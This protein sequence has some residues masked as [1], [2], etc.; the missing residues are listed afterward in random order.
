M[1][2]ASEIDAE[3]AADDGMERGVERTDGWPAAEARQDFDQR[4]RQERQR[5]FAQAREVF[6]DQLAEVI[7]THRPNKLIGLERAAATLSDEE[8]HPLADAVSI[9]IQLIPV[10]APTTIQAW[11]VGRN[12]MLGDRAPALVVRDDPNAVRQ[13]AEYFLAYG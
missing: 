11:F 7:L 2:K 9:A 6:G 10:E 3:N 8:F 13:A 12:R 4:R 5:L 1:R